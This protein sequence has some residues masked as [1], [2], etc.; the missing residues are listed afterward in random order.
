MNERALLAAIDESPSDPVPRLV[1]ADWLEEC[2][3]PGRVALSRLVRRS[4]KTVRSPTAGLRGALTRE[5]NKLA[6]ERPTAVSWFDWWLGQ[7]GLSEGWMISVHEIVELREDHDRRQLARFVTRTARETPAPG[8]GTVFTHANE[9]GLA[10]L[11]L[12]ERYADGEDLSDADWQ[13]TRPWL[14][15]GLRAHWKRYVSCASYSSGHRAEN[16]VEPD[17]LALADPNVPARWARWAAVTH[18]SR[19]AGIV[20]DYKLEGPIR[21]L[22]QRILHECVSCPFDPDGD[23]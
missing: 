8:G 9:R 6:K 4:A 21:S 19:C 13:S 16:T 12:L 20:G 18:S 2:G 14:S 23:G 3:T 17:V 22:H 7:S 10:I 11:G 5:R 1:L 15:P